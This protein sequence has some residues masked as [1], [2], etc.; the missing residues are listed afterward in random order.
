VFYATQVAT[1]PPTIVL[2]TNGPQLFDD[3]YARYLIKTFRDNLPFR[4]VPIKLYIRHKRH[5]GSAAPDEVYV[6][7]GEKPKRQGRERKGGARTGKVRRGI[8][9]ALWED[10]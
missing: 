1:S 10:V 8:E 2:F 4:D 6:S 9:S 7:S 5:G 3:T